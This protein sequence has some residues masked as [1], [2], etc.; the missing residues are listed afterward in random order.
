MLYVRPSTLP[1]SVLQSKAARLKRRRPFDQ[2]TVSLTNGSSPGHSNGAS[3]SPETPSEDVVDSATVDC[4]PKSKHISVG[5]FKFFKNNKCDNN[6]TNNETVK[7]YKKTNKKY[8]RRELC[9]IVETLTERLPLNF[10][11]VNAKISALN[12]KQEHMMVS[13]RKRI[14]RE[15]ERVCLEDMANKRSKPKTGTGQTA[16]VPQAGPSHA[17]E[18]APPKPYNGVSNSRRDTPPS[19]PVSSYSINSLLSISDDSP[20][21]DKKSSSSAYK[22]ESPASV[23][24]PDPSPSPEHL[25]RSANWSRSSPVY[26]STVSYNTRPKYFYPEEVPPV[27]YHMYP[28]YHLPHTSYMGAYPGYHHPRTPP[29]WLQFPPIPP[30]PWAPLAHPLVTDHAPRDDTPSGIK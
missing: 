20:K 27:P 10:I 26:M 6:T 9:K 19:K 21:E 14:L 22:T 30:G 11:P 16:T 28:S 5:K 29:L 23:H 3:S 15:L 7:V 2:G 12:C 25:R 17:S 24:S 1:A 18:S 4:E 8:K 13:P